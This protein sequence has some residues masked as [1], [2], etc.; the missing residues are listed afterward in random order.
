MKESCKTA[1]LVAVA[2]GYLLGR[3]KKAKLAL[4]LGS[5]LAGRRIGLDPQELLRKGAQKVAETPQFEELSEQIRDELV[6]AARSAVRAVA[7]RRID[8]FTDS[9]RQRSARLNGENGRNGEGGEDSADDQNGREDAADEYGADDG[10]DGHGGG[11]TDDGDGGDGDEPRDA[12]AARREKGASRR[13]SSAHRGNG[14][15][16]SPG[17]KSGKP[18]ERAGHKGGRHA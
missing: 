6:T 4:V 11:D 1:V 18:A 5:L 3:T 16:K 14:R 2:G 12:H 13:P 17:G 8:T 10:G 9:L 7:D 15:K